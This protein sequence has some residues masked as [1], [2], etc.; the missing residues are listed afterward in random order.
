MLYESL[1]V[2]SVSGSPQ[3]KLPTL[4]DAAFDESIIGGDLI[5]EVRVSTVRR[6][7]ANLVSNAAGFGEH[8]AISVRRNGSRIEII[9]DDDGPGIPKDQIEEALKPFSRLDE[10]RNQ[11]R[12][13][14]GLGLAITRDVARNH[15]GELRLGDSPMG[16]LRAVLSLPG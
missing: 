3:E 7:I 16:G 9:V 8:V 5:A 4:F 15:G 14:V 10:S 11:N 1:G 2:C 13:G 12:K 6:A